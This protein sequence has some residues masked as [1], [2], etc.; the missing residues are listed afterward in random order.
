MRNLDESA[1]DSDVMP[2]PSEIDSEH[3][4]HVR[5]LEVELY[6]EPAELTAIPIVIAMRKGF[7]QSALN[8]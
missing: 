7:P 2:G 4:G 1:R 5:Q 3:V 8:D 6:E